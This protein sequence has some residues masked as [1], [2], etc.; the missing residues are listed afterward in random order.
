M[1]ALC[2][3]GIAFRKQ[4]TSIAHDTIFYL[5][6]NLFIFET[7]KLHYDF[8]TSRCNLNKINIPTRDFVDNAKNTYILLKKI[9]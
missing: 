7:T 6:F 1:Y 2:E 8:C 4:E 9:N 5:Q 3:H